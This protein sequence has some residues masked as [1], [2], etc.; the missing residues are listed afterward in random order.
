MTYNG[1]GFGTELI[2]REL[3]SPHAVKS[4]QGGITNAYFNKMVGSEWLTKVIQ[5]TLRGR[6]EVATSGV[7]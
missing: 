7:S 2:V 5:G 4:E 1:Q 3:G 6:L